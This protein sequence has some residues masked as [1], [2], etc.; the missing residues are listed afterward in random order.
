[1]SD[2]MIA[3]D[4]RV[5]AAGAAQMRERD[6]PT[7]RL[8]KVDIEVSPAQLDAAARILREG[9][10][11]QITSVT[12][13]PRGTVDF[14]PRELPGFIHASRQESPDVLVMDVGILPSKTY[15]IARDGSTVGATPPG[16]SDA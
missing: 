1:M 12:G 7:A 9:P 2:P 11:S 5:L 4:S 3:V 14:D 13:A 10:K 16:G 15:R 8:T 6:E